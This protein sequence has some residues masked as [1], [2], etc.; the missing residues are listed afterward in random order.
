[1][2][3]FFAWCLF[4]I[5]G[6]QSYFWEFVRSILYERGWHML[7]PAA[8]GVGIDT[9]VH[10]SLTIALIGGG[11]WLFWPSRPAFMRRKPF[12]LFLERDSESDQLGIQTFPAITYIQVA[13]SAM[14]LLN[15]CRF[16]ISSVDFS[17]DG[18]EPFAVENNKR[19][20]C[21][22]SRHG[23]NDDYEIDI[24]PEDPPIRANVAVFN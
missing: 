6:L 23:G 2:R 9:V 19:Y 5:A 17:E 1:M 4:V 13:V 12:Q 18:T 11:T 21:R 20:N 7:A 24:R 22:W 14:T 15:R 3:S 16:F 10:Y 8:E